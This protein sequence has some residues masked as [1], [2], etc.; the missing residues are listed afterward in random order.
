MTLRK[1]L[2]TALTMFI[3]LLAFLTRCS[4][5]ET[6]AGDWTALKIQYAKANL[7]LAQARLALAVHQNQEVPDSVAVGTMESLQAGVQIAQG[8]L[9]RLQSNQPADPYASLIIDAEAR[10][11]GAEE[12]FQESMRANRIQAGTIPEV[13]LRQERAE[14]DVAKTRLAL[15]KTLH[16]QPVD[17]RLQWEIRELQDEVRALWNRPLLED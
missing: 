11:K 4:A 13:L 7:E 9:E 10:V 17:V 15:L 1:A 12:K 14:L 3:F 16:E 6:N 5:Q 8:R 2:P